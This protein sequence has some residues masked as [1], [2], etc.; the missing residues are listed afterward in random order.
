VDLNGVSARGGTIFSQYLPWLSHNRPEYESGLISALNSFV[1]EGDRVVVVG[2][3][4][5][6]T[7]ILAAK[8]A[9]VSGNVIV[10]EGSTFFAD[11]VSETALLNNVQS[12]VEVR[13]S[14]VGSNIHIK[15]DTHGDVINADELPKCDVLELDC[16]GAEIDILN[17]LEIKPRV[18]LVESHGSKGSPSDQ[19][20]STLNEQNYTVVDKCIAD[21]G[22]EKMCMNNDIYVLSSIRGW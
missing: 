21:L 9:G 7:A 20:A 13:N 19:I 1:N 2:G 17:N 15:G 8:L 14:I 16:E 18:I 6:A 3:G 12:R 5:G 22:E 11:V 10:Y 4:W